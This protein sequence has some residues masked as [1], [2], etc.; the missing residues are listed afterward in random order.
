[1]VYPKSRHGLSDPKLIRQW[2]QMM[3]DFITANL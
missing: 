2:R 3:I 1:M